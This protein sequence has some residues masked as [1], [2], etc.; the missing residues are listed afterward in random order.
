MRFSACVLALLLALLPGATS[1]QRLDWND[2]VAKAKGQTV[3][4]N[5]WAGDE[6]TNAFLQ[7]VGEEVGRRYGVKLVHVKLKDTAEAVTRVVAEKAAGRNTGGTVDLIWIN[8]PNFLAMKQQSLLFGP[9]TQA[10][11]SYARVDTTNIRSNVVDFTIPVEGMESPW[12]RAQIVFVYDS[13]RVANPP[14]S[15][16]ELLEWAKKNPGRLTHPA[17]RNFLGATFL[18]QA[19]W[20]LAPD[21]SVL[22]RPATDD[23]FA[24]VTAPMWAWYDALRPYLWRQGKQLPENGPAQRQLLNDG[25]IDMLVSFNPA[26]AAVSVNAGLLPDSVRTVVFARGTIGNTSF[27]AIPYNAA[28]KEGAMVVADFLLEPATQAYAQDFRQM[29]N[30]T[31][32]DFATLSPNEKRRFDEL[33]KSPALPTNAELGTSLLEPHPSWMTRI[34]N[35]WEKR[36]TK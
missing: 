18:K 24:A 28:N 21:P 32:L 10:L 13:K 20:E 31:V 34:A 22:Q 1:A 4:F 6:K 7:W 11:P 2:I 5:A 25:E 3:N 30:F 12:R 15:V 33:P 14:R 19:L 35:E 36:Y 9:F 27:V 29:G 8:G 16:P 23:N 17:V 26:E